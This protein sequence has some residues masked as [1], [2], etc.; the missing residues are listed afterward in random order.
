MI[1]NFDLEREKHFHDR[2]IL[3]ALQ[4]TAFVIAYVS[5]IIN[6]TGNSCQGRQDFMT[7]ALDQTIKSS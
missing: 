6:A 3:F 4:S 2:C 5:F 1:S 7:Q